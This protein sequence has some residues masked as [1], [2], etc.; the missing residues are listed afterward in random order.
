VQRTGASRF[1][2]SQIQR[3]RR[4]ARVVDLCVRTLHRRDDQLESKAL[5]LL[6]LLGRVVGG[7]LVAF[8]LCM[9]AYS[10]AK[11]DWTVA[12]VSLV[13]VVLIV[14]RLSRPSRPPGA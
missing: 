5:S 13:M 12:A 2:Q 11:S 10:V 8:G 14:L 7:W 9:V 3:Q 6:N 4:L 1:A